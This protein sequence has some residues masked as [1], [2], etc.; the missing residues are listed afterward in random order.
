MIG[1]EMARRKACNVGLPL[2]AAEYSVEISSIPQD[3]FT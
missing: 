3:V 1:L 2:S